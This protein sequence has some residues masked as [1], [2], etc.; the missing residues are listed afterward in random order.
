LK[1]TRP[2][3][4]ALYARY[5]T[6][7]HAANDPV[8]FLHG[9]PDPLDREVVGLLAACLA[10]GRLKQIMRSVS[11]AVGRLGA[12][13]ARLLRRAG[14]R[15]LRS[16]SSSFVHRLL[17]ETRLCRLLEAMAGALRDHGS[18]QACFRS[19]DQPGARTVVRG[20]KGMAAELKDGR[21]ELTHVLA[22]PALGSA[23]KRWNLYLRWMVR[24][25][26][27][28]PGGWEGIS[29]SRL[30]VPLDAHMGRV[31]RALGMT[32]R[33]ASDLKAALE[34]TERFRLIRPDDP[35]R[36]DFALMHWSAEGG[37]TGEQNAPG[38]LDCGGAPGG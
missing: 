35:V 23:C 18:L 13:P 8:A 31:C 27:V 2:Y 28:D 29:P 37:K 26:E 4:E 1:L 34:V 32:K 36:Y 21:P 14:K 6:R 5:N 15:E 12:R 11:D 3:L 25:D 19:H 30:I 7:E 24:R 20:L 22:D 33:R 9:Y 38:W 17:D 10:Y 16:I